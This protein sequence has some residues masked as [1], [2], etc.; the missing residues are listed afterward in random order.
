MLDHPEYKNHVT[1]KSSPEYY[2]YMDLK[3]KLLP[4][5]SRMQELE[6]TL[7]QRERHEGQHQQQQQ[8]Q[9]HTP[10]N[11]EHHEEH[12]SPSHHVQDIAGIFNHM[13][14]TPSSTG[15]SAGSTSRTAANGASSLTSAALA[16]GAPPPVPSTSTKPP[17]PVPSPS[18]KP[19]FPSPTS[20]AAAKPGSPSQPTSTHHG[21]A[22][23]GAATHKVSSR[24]KERM[25]MLHNAGMKDVHE[26]SHDEHVRTPSSASSLD[27]GKPAVNPKPTI[28]GGL[29]RSPAVHYGQTSTA[30]SS[31]HSNG[32]DST[33]PVSHSNGDQLPSLASTIPSQYSQ[34]DSM[35]DPWPPKSLAPKTSTEGLKRTVPSPDVSALPDTEDRP[36]SAPPAT[37]GPPD[38]SGPASSSVD[39]LTR[40]YESATDTYLTQTNHDRSTSHSPALDTPATL[41]SFADRFPDV[42]H[43]ASFSSPTQH[44]PTPTSH[45]GITQPF[46]PAPNSQNTLQY[47]G[48]NVR[49]GRSDT[50]SSVQT[51]STDGSTDTAH[52]MP[53]GYLGQMSPKP[54]APSAQVS[55]P[56]RP[57][58]K[59]PSLPSLPNRAATTIEPQEL[60]RFLEASGSPGQPSILLVD[61]RT[62]KEYSS[63]H[64]KG[65]TVCIEPF[66]LSSNSSAWSIENSLEVS[67]DM[68]RKW[69]AE[70]A[71]F[72]LIVMYDK[73]TKALP[74]RDSASYS[75]TS[76]GPVTFRSIADQVEDSAVS[77][78]TLATLSKAIYELNFSDADKRLKRSPLLLVGGFEAW[79]KQIGDKGIQQEAYAQPQYHHYHQNRDRPHEHHSMP[80]LQPSR[81]P[82]GPP[83]SHQS[84]VESE[85]Q[86][87]VMLTIILFDIKLTLSGYLRQHA[88]Q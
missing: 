31:A 42:E 21:W 9:S 49:T 77:A 1:H 73:S 25:A 15:G 36:G 45:S 56:P 4:T 87:S 74:S 59:P 78:R 40:S 54:P 88:C 14:V 28:N 43:V 5:T 19:A 24:L 33:L 53:N 8:A 7:M 81:P 38:A 60:W 11:G 64:V 2:S 69:F 17:P 3:S 55:K 86:R 70:R 41:D 47:Q 6:R 52:R 65:K 79:A 61:V 72:D 39:W 34:D 83:A 76:S 13:S 82:S 50:Q 68:E 66:T 58:P 48:M 37:N 30:T 26:S 23:M 57:L 80:A 35:P 67:P 16:K 29:R 22:G 75:N 20:S 27:G 85:Y 44:R 18:S 12:F 84:K 63:G 62:R 71:S 10:V 51:Q 32:S 46:L